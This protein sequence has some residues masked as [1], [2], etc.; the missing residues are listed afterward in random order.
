MTAELAED[1]PAW[2]GLRAVLIRPDGY[3][4]WATRTADPPPLVSCLGTP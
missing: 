4:A 1:Y 2:A 3:L